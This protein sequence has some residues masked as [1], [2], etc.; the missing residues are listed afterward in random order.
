MA[1]DMREQSTQPEWHE[2]VIRERLERMDRDPRPGTTWEDL[3][4]QLRIKRESTAKG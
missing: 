3:R 1:E 4:E 2:A